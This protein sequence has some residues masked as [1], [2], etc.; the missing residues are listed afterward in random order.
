MTHDFH[1][2]LAYSRR[3]AAERFWHDVYTKHFGPLSRFEPVRDLALQ[4]EGIDRIIALA[5]TGRVL[6][7]EEKED[8]HAAQ[9]FFLETVSGVESGAPGWMVR[10][11][12]SDWLAYAFIPKAGAHFVGGEALM[13]AHRC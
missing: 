5:R 1:T 2:D 13:P 11:L 6:R 7:I 8:R 12:S 3:P 10:P 9:N 4:G